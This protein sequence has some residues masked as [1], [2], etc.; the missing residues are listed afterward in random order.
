MSPPWWI[1]TP[2]LWTKAARVTAACERARETGL[3]AFSGASAFVDEPLVEA[4]D[5]GDLAQGV[6]PAS[7]GQ[8]TK[9][10]Q[11]TSDLAHVVRRAMDERRAAERAALDTDVE[12]ERARGFVTYADLKRPGFSMFGITISFYLGAVLA[13]PLIT[14]MVTLAFP[15]TLQSL[16]T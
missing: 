9:P 6:E 16:G 5:V 4:L 10:A 13:Y 8:A 12:R 3:E 15:F 11:S 1:A 2:P 14:G 7:T